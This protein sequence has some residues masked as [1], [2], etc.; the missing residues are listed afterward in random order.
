MERERGREFLPLP[1]STMSEDNSPSENAEENSEEEDV[2]MKT[3]IYGFPRE[4]MTANDLREI[5]EG[6]EE[7]GYEMSST[8][9]GEKIIIEREK[10]SENSVDVSSVLES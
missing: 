2:Q 9:D 1:D 3:M 4:A 5:K 6:L 8:E 10:N 7:R